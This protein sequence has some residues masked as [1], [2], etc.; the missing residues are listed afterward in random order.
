MEIL[1]TVSSEN[2]MPTAKYPPSLPVTIEK[3]WLKIE[4]DFLNKSIV[5]EEQI[6]ILAKQKINN[7]ELDVGELVK[8][9]SI[10]FSTGADS[11]STFDKKD[12]QLNIQNGKVS[13]D[14]EHTINEG[15][16]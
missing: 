2:N 4:P 3:I 15:E 12:L 10:F 16:R 6:K 7:V 11:H 8:I 9:K 13:I 5:A 1:E 14:L